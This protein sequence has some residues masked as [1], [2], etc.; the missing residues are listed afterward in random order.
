MN[1]LDFS[2]ELLLMVCAYILKYEDKIAVSGTC[3]RLKNLMS[4]RTVFRKTSFSKAYY[5]P[6]IDVKNFILPGRDY[7]V[8]LNLTSCCYLDPNDILR[9]ALKL[10]NLKIFYV[11][12]TKFSI[13]HILAL[14]DENKEIT[15]LSL[16]WNQR[17]YLPTESDYLRCSGLGKVESLFI[18]ITPGRVHANVWPLIIACAGLQ[19]L[20]ITG[21][22]CGYPKDHFSSLPKHLRSLQLSF[23]V[24]SSCSHSSTR[25]FNA[26][27]KC[28]TDWDYFIV[29][30]KG[31]N[32]YTARTNPD[33]LRGWMENMDNM[34]HAKAM[35]LLDEMTFTNK[36]M[37]TSKNLCLASA[38]V[39]TDSNDVYFQR[40]CFPMLRQLKIFSKEQLEICQH[41][42]LPHL[43]EVFIQG[44][45]FLLNTV[46][47]S[48]LKSCTELTKLCLPLCIL[49]SE[50]D[51]QAV[52]SVE[53]TALFK[54]KR[55]R[56][57]H[58][59]QSRGTSV[60]RELVNSS[61]D[62]RELD[63]RSHTIVGNFLPQ[64][65]ASMPS[66]V[67]AEAELWN[68]ALLHNLERLVL[69]DVP[70]RTGAFFPE[71]AQ[72]CSRLS[73]L[74]LSNLGMYGLCTYS[75]NLVKALPKFKNL[76]DFRMNVW[77]PSL[78]TKIHSYNNT[79]NA[80]IRSEEEWTRHV[81]RNLY[82]TFGIIPGFHLV[83]MVFHPCR[84]S[85][86]P[87]FW[88]SYNLFD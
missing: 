61:H 65:T 9:L 58:V 14:L 74:H 12:D 3:Q 49:K 57:A 68:V 10:T 79:M 8:E 53:E 41:L 87:C 88:E 15:K 62:L 28:S 45:D 16:T 27:A 51:T 76:K 73:S 63:I 52:S 42:S 67:E 13:H 23:K 82:Y 26:L 66:Q 7:V 30:Y 85:V 38:D 24:C 35:C 72:S 44:K 86:V 64:I 81:V 31:R 56:V 43:K 80:P 78:I 69:S 59:A 40:E 20:R 46:D 60:F 17:V 29:D 25:E 33:Y 4:D 70:I 21:L 48:F 1:L 18:Y 55:C 5:V 36:N 75:A 37:F 54:P 11:A 39:F 47:W 19:Q 77:R 50:R 6:F 83:E 34:Q 22:T 2:D 71:V 32:M 84:V